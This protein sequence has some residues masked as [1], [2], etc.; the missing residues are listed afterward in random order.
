MQIPI[1]IARYLQAKPNIEEAGLAY[2]QAVVY[3][4]KKAK[5]TPESYKGY[6]ALT[7]IATSYIDRQMWPEAVDALVMLL[8]QYPQSEDSLRFF[9]M[10]HL[11][12]LG[13]LKNP[14]KAIDIYQDFITKHPKH[15]LVKNL[16]TQ[17]E[18]LKKGEVKK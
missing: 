11:I 4:Q 3:Y 12:C 15:P 18:N 9:Q 10:I 1:Y 13:Q 6:M 5:E 7:L 16:E 2:Q 17:I 14:Q 8:E